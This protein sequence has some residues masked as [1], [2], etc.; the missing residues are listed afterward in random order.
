MY[1]IAVTTTRSTIL[2]VTGHSS[3]E[4]SHE[5]DDLSSSDIEAISDSVSTPLSLVSSKQSP[6]RP[7]ELKSKHCPYP[8]CVKSFNRQARLNEHIRSHTNTRLFVCPHPPCTKDFL[9][10]THL[11][12][13]IKSAHSDVRDYTCKYAGCGKSFATGTRLKRHHAAHEGREKYKCDLAGCG[14]TFR[15]HGTL[16]AH[17]VS[18]HEGKNPFTCVELGGDGS[19]CGAEFDTASKLKT[20]KGRLHGRNRYY[21]NICRDSSN[22]AS[23]DRTQHLEEVVFPTYA[24]LTAHTKEVHPPICTHCGL[25]CTTARSLKSHVDIQHG[26]LDPTERNV[27]LCPEPSCGQ[28]FTKRG[29][30]L[31]HIKAVHA[32]ER[33]FVCGT[34]TLSLL[35]RVGGWHGNDACGKAYTSKSSLEE[36]IRTAH[37]GLDHS[38]KGKSNA[39]KAL[40][41]RKGLKNAST[42]GHLTGTAHGEKEERNIPCLRSN[43]DFR[44]G[45]EYDLEMHMQSKH[46][47]ADFEI[48]YLRTERDEYGPSTYGYSLATERD[49]ADI[50]AERALDEQSGMTGFDEAVDEEHDGDLEEALE[51]A[52]ARGGQFWLSGEFDEDVPGDKWEADQ[53]DMQRLVEENDDENEGDSADDRDEM[54]IDP[55]LL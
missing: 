31:V 50:E 21:C 16:Q 26:P 30:L 10:D 55:V 27:Y 19:V 53:R 22:T 24:A 54:M 44:F 17:M 38:R 15:K 41:R 23:D 37:L 48:Q 35:N 40:K 45:R 34:A 51:E 28:A 13:H 39:N 11:K 46:G 3:P 12:H 2:T 33:A 9:R 36:H 32:N 6:K 25:Q 1:E 29:N 52:A 43:C 20:H 42:M 5:D 7:S 47:L 49:E 8:D 14:L 18:V 4:S